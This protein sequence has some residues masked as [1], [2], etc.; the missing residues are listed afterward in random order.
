MDGTDAAFPT[1]T[2]PL[3]RSNKLL[4]VVE[5]EQT[6]QKE[7]RKPSD[8]EQIALIDWLRTVEVW[9]EKI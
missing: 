7:D 4:L 2:K 1:P 5:K 3:R 6:L 8:R 9:T